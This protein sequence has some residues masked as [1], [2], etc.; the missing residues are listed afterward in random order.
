MRV[1]VLGS[2]GMAGH[3]IAAWLKECGWDVTGFARQ[4]STICQTVVGD[5]ENYEIVHSL[6]ETGAYQLVVNAIGLLNQ[7]VDRNPQRG[8]HLNAELPHRLARSCHG[9]GCQLVHI[10]TDC[11]FSGKKGSYEEEDFPDATSLYGQTKSRGEVVDDENLTIRTSIVGPELKENG[12]GLYHWFMK[13]DGEVHGYRKVLWSGV[14]TLELAKFIEKA[15]GCV[16][17]RWHLTNNTAI[18]K[19]ELLRL[20][21]QYARK[22]KV[23]IEPVDEPVC[24]KSLRCTRRDF[25]YAVPE[26]EKMVQDMGAWIRQ[27]REWYHGYRI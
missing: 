15:A 3:M 25:S 6:I 18:S 7:A 24:D 14:T 1:L 22:D 16:T 2:H 9:A 23:A 19:Y 27:H 11:V 26:Y 20:F 12:I 8:T 4:A 21:N 10:S 5:A 13:Q 17:G